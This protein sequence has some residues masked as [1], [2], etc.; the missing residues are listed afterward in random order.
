[1]PVFLFTF[2]LTVT[3]N[4]ALGQSDEKTF[5]EPKLG[6]SLKYPSDWNFTETIDLQNTSAFYPVFD[7]DFCPVQIALV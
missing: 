5:V 7:A 1:M 3:S 4:N 2:I 6:L